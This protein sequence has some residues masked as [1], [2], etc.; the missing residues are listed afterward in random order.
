MDPSPL[1]RGMRTLAALAAASWLL[2][3]PGTGTAR[4]AASDSL[5]VTIVPRDVW[6]PTPV[7]DLVA[8]PGAEGQIMLQWTAPDS[9]L[10]ALGTLTPAAGY[11]IRI[12]SFSVASVGGSTT[13]WWG[14][15][16]DVRA[17]PPPALSAVPPAPGAPGAAENLLLNQLEPGV[18]IY[19][20]LVSSDTAGQLSDSDLPSRTPLAQANALVFDAVPPA[21]ASITAAQNGIGSVLVSWPASPAS[22]RDYYRVLV[23]S[24]APRDF[25]DEYAVVVDSPSLTTTLSGL[26]AGVYALRV[27]VV[28]K[29]LPSHA[30]IALA[31]A[32]ASS[33]TVTVASSILLP[34]A[35]FGVAMSSAGAAVTVSWMPVGRYEDGAGFADPNAALSAELSAYRVYRA[36]S[37]VAGGWVQ[38]IQLSSSTLTWTDLAGGPQ[39]FYHVRAE[40][41]SG[42]SARSVFRSVGTLSAFV[43]AP[44][45]RSYFEVPSQSV[46]PIEGTAGQAPTAYLAAAAARPQDLGGRVVKSIEFTA[47]QGGQTL[48]PNFSLPAMGRLKLRYEMSASS[49]VPS[50]MS[51]AA[52]PADP[53]NIGVYWYNGSAWV[54]MYGR[55]DRTDQSLNLET[56]YFGIYQLRIVERA[57]EFA[58]DQAGV[59]NRFVTPNGDGRN[60]AVVFSYDNPKDVSVRAR[61]LDRKGRVIVPEL[62]QGPVT[63]SR[64]WDGRAGGAY[65]PGGVYLYQ[66][67]GEGRVFSGTIVIL[68]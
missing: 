27:A 48:A 62:P 47:M 11:L 23:D 36:T 19:A 14:A 68:K 10:N 17:L 29:G 41:D 5:T 52:V 15:A 8:V 1:K 12:A 44:D 63:N 6:P 67:E 43:I 16:A 58:F 21:P 13:A 3:V 46:L 51:A 26:S 22:D 66:I 31:S 64:V 40:N 49:V 42:L 24:T 56:K 61:I 18:T 57:T 45:D 60:D 59:S 65:V 53:N 38:Q 2:A 35:P 20:M 50:G 7:T 32:A 25:A 4:A 54:Q 34:Q 33:T 39:Y 37:V 28:D 55:L 9:N 30:G